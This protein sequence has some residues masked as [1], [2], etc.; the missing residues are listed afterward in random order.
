[1]DKD[2]HSIEEY[3]EGMMT[4]EEKLV[5]EQ[6]LS[7]EPAL[8]KAHEME[9]SARELI[10]QAGRLELKNTLE[11]LDAQIQ[12]EPI[13]KSLMPMWV[14]NSMRVAALLILFVA[15]YQVFLN[16][17][18]VN[19]S[20]VYDTYFETYAAPSLE[21]DGRTDLN[22]NLV[23]ESYQNEA[24]KEALVFLKKSEGEVPDY[25]IDFYTGMSL[26]AV[27]PPEF[28]LAV[29][30]FDKV[31]AT[32]NDYHQQAE[33][34]MGLAL[35]KMEKEEEAVVLF[36]RIVAAKNYQY[37]EAKSILKLDFE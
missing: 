24:Y 31:L 28:G 4:S 34:Y 32:D 23:V 5:F 35:L 22:W 19:T 16:S 20:E 36:K 33:W 27:Q 3:L 21:R 13:Q 8:S 1:M 18:A 25:L 7:Q 11:A 15:V 10:M 37:E 6:R 30:N 2:Q 14:K 12:N 26:M 9:I 17:D 29:Q